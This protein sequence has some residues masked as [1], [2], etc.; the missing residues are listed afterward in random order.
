MAQSTFFGS[1]DSIAE[2]VAALRLKDE[3]AVRVAKAGIPVPKQ[4]DKSLY[5]EFPGDITDI[6]DKDLGRFLGI[7]EAEA[8]WTGYCIARREIDQEHAQ[9]LL[10]FAKNKMSCQFRAQFP[11]ESATQLKERVGADSFYLACVMEVKSL[12][13][14]LKLLNSSKE[15]FER[16]AK[17]ISREIT[18]R[19]DSRE[20]YP[21]R[22]V[23]AP[24]QEDVF[25]NHG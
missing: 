22:R 21:V 5:Q 25:V 14:D 10:E 12:E 20:S 18:N 11:Q 3:A 7:Y 16:Y 8:A 19:K 2:E 23:T 24:G 1:Q 6:P 15:S 4:P 13:A 17:A 9:L